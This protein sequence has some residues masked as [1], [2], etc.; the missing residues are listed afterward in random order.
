MICCKQCFCLI[1]GVKT[2]KKYKSSRKKYFRVKM[3]IPPTLIISQRPHDVGVAGS[4]VNNLGWI[5]CNTLAIIC[6]DTHENEH[7]K[8]GGGGIKTIGPTK[9]YAASNLHF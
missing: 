7:K 9:S 3:L 2:Y 4:H 5:G 6:C 8:C 1:H